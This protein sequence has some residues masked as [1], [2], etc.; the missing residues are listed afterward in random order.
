[1]SPTTVFSMWISAVFEAWRSTENTP[2]VLEL[3]G[4]QS[5]L[6]N[7]LLHKARSYMKHSLQSSWGCPALISRIE[8]SLPLPLGFISHRWKPT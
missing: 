4:I 1:M 7:S 3:E 6:P 8:A 2:K 5:I